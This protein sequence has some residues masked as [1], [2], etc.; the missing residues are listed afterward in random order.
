VT[1]VWTRGV[2]FDV[3]GRRRAGGRRGSLVGGGRPYVCVR[4][5]GSRESYVVSRREAVGLW[6]GVLTPASTS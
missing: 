1:S 5:S 4:G 6:C 2:A 3:P